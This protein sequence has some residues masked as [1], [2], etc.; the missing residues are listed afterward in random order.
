MK[1][2]SKTIAMKLKQARD[3]EK[4]GDKGVYGKKLHANTSDVLNVQDVGRHQTFNML[5]GGVGSGDADQAGRK[6][7]IK[8]RRELLKREK[9]KRKHEKKEKN[10]QKDNT[11]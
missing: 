2:V 11:A 9:E 10:T 8:M 7:Q 1:V 4:Q 6:H 3:K 5:H